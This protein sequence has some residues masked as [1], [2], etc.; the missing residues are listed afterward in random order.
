MTVAYP[1]HW[2]EG[3]KRDDIVTL[4]DAE[5]RYRRRAKDIHTDAGGDHEAMVKLNGAI[6]QARTE[7]ST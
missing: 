4:A 3:F 6:A 2:P 7:L 5:L 1:L